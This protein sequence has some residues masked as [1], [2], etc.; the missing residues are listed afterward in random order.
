[1]AGDFDEVEC[2]CKDDDGW[3]STGALVGIIVAAV[4]VVALLCFCCW[5]YRAR[6]AAKPEDETKKGEQ[7]GP[8]ATPPSATR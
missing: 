2:G 7:K 8:V 1:M 3:L 4:V 5:R 6:R